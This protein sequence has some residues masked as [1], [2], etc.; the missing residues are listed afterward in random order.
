M[1]NLKD[2]AKQSMQVRIPWVT[3]KL[4]TSHYR[5]WSHNMIQTM[6]EKIHNGQSM[7]GLDP[8]V[9]AGC[10]NNLEFIVYVKM[11]D[12]PEESLGFLA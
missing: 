8:L 7:V 10:K 1:V 11:S 4:Q 12:D 9:Y 2:N 3:F 5:V 6:F